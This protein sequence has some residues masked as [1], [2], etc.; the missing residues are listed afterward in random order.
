MK[1]IEIE[2]LREQYRELC[3]ALLDLGTLVNPRGIQ[4]YE[5]HNVALVL[6]IKTAGSLPVG[7]NRKVSPA[8]F[9]AELMQWVSGVSDLRQLNSASRGAFDDFAESGRLYGA[10]GP[11]AFRGL[12]RV[13]RILDRDPQSRQATLSIWRGDESE[14]TKDLPCTVSWS[15]IIR[16]GRLHMT[17]FMRSNDIWTGV[18]YDVP[19]M[20]RIQ[21]AVAWCLGVEVG[22]YTHIAQSFHMYATDID[23]V[24]SLTS[25][26]DVDQP[27]FLTIES[28][29]GIEPFAPDRWRMIRD[30]W[31]RPALR[32]WTPEGAAVPLPPEFEYYAT[33][34]HSCP[35]NDHWCATCRYYL[36]SPEGGLECT[37]A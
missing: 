30:G 34:L 1:V 20:T 19:A 16:D 28:R 26:L 6:P 13:V 4:T 21:H 31:A 14:S 5:M 22:V 23:K 35:G 37:P 17:T 2:D 7:I 33:L 25:P 18:A 11:R 24:S 32:A 15:F 3:E 12:E 10:Y 9:A 8:V 29:N 27:P 36:E